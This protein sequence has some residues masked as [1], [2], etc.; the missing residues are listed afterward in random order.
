MVKVY[1]VRVGTKYGPEYETYLKDKLPSIE[2]LNKEEH[3]FILQWNKL[4]F[5]YVFFH[6]YITRYMEPLIRSH[7]RADDDLGSIVYD[8]LYEFRLLI[9]RISYWNYFPWEVLLLT[10]T[11]DSIL[12]AM[13]NVN[14]KIGMN[15][16]PK[17]KYTTNLL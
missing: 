12:L 9:D 5:I 8:I 13:N 16:L 2:F 3:P 7:N 17:C 11:I 10:D 6:L 15:G 1:A 4:R 14:N